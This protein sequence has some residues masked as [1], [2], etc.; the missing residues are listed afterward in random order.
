M[1]FKSSNLG[2][3]IEKN[4]SPGKSFKT[5]DALTIFLNTFTIFVSV[6]KTV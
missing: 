3:K 2:K 5:G 6:L 4:K 1:V